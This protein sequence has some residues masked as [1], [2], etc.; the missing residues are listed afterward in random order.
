MRIQKKGTKSR[1]RRHSVL[2]KH[3]LGVNF[4]CE[5]IIYLCINYLF[6]FTFK[7]TNKTI[8]LPIH[9]TERNTQATVKKLLVTTLNVLAETK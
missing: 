2:I 4:V 7:S 9:E 1:K 5:S 8:K 6:S 3:K